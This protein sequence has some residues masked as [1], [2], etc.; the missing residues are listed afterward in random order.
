MTLIIISEWKKIETVFINTH[1][2]IVI[3]MLYRKKNIDDIENRVILNCGGH[4]HETYKV[5]TIQ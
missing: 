1:S 3:V 4:R 5:A 2:I